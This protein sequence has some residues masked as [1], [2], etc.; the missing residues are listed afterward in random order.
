MEIENP[1]LKCRS[2][3]NNGWLH[4]NPYFARSLFANMAGPQGP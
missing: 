4:G 1:E 2:N 3:K